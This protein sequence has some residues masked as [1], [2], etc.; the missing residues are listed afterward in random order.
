M[1]RTSEKMHDMLIK[2]IHHRGEDRIGVFFSY[3]S[4]LVSIIR[5]VPGRRF[6]ATKK[7]W[8]LPWDLTSLLKLKAL[9][10][11]K[12]IEEIEKVLSA[13]TMEQGKSPRSDRESVDLPPLDPGVLSGIEEMRRW[14]EQKRYS[15]STVKTY[16]S[17]MRQFFAAYPEIARDEID[18]GIIE[19]VTTQPVEFCRY[20]AHFYPD[21]EG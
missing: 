8:Y 10:N 20:F 19:R 16:V 5:S 9:G 13:R 2:R 4:E 18:R 11:V 15:T 14:M 6:S 7:C 17:F 1:R 12:G 21:P 3:H